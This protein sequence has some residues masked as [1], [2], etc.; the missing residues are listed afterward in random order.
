MYVLVC[1]SHLFYRK[2]CTDTFYL[3][4]LIGT[5]E[6]S[7]DTNK[8][9]H[10]VLNETFDVSDLIFWILVSLIN[11]EPHCTRFTSVC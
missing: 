8:R 1:P 5:V 7:R 6:T 2:S 3:S 10:P 4:T 11:L 9:R